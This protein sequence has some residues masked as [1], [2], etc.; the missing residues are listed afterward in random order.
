MARSCKV[1]VDTSIVWHIA[2]GTSV[3]P[4]AR[5]V[6]SE[7]RRVCDLVYTE[8]NI[9]D[10]VSNEKLTREEK[11]R[12]IQA[13]RDIARREE[14][15]IDRG[16]VLGRYGK[17]VK[18]LGL[19]DVLIVIAARELGAFL[20]TADWKQVSLFKESLG[21]T[22]IYLPLYQLQKVVESG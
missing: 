6:V 14:V 8:Y 1:V 15:R 16:Y 10:V 22:P 17:W 12:L 3:A 5:G 20:L 18:R 7:L 19:R 11:E 13:Y 2:F 4:V 21:G 9:E